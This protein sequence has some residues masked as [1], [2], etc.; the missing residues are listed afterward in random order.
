MNQKVYFVLVRM[1]PNA[2][3]KYFLSG[4]LYILTRELVLCTAFAGQDFF[5]VFSFFA[6]VLQTFAL[7][8]L[9]FDVNSSRKK[10]KNTKRW[11][12]T[13]K[14]CLCLHTKC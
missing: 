1:F 9:V 13:L 12:A 4:L 8:W 3:E 2:S 5:A 14:N 6:L 10:G 7:F 11:C